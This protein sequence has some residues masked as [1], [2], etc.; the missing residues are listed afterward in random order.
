MSPAADSPA[1]PSKLDQNQGR[2]KRA[3][4]RRLTRHLQVPVEDP[5]AVTVIHGIDELLEVF[6]GFV[7]LQPPMADLQ[8]SRE[9]A[10]ESAHESGKAAQPLRTQSEGGGSELT[11]LSNS[12][13]PVTNSSTRYI[14]VLLA[15]TCARGNQIAR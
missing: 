4:R 12:S 14:F 8:D 5:A 7:L 13:P 15:I 11:I 1:G 6:P 10:K 9:M 2:F 3:N